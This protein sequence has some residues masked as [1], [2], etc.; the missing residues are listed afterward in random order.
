MLRRTL[1]ALLVCLSFSIRAAAQTLTLTFLNVGQADATLVLTPEGRTILVDAGGPPGVMAYLDELEIDTL[2]LVIASHNHSD[3]IGGM[4]EVLETVP[5]RFYLDNGVPHTTATYRRALTALEQ[6]GA[7]YL[8][9]TAR[10]I[11]VGSVQVRILPLPPG[12]EG[13]ND[14]SVGV[15]LEFGEFRALLTGDSEIAELAY[16]L[17]NAAV[18]EMHVLKVAH[19]GSRNGTTRAW[20]EHTR[21]EVAVISVG[22][23]NSYGHP[24]PQVVA[25]WHDVGADVLRTDL[26]GTIEINAARDG[27]FEIATDE[28][29]AEAEAAADTAPALSCC[30]IC[31]T[32]KACGNSCISR[33]LT[34]HRPPGCACNAKP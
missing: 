32:G 11:T 23:G 26:H 15:V 19:H 3:H 6:S 18:P 25:Q 2:D 27:S 21:P 4:A 34:C 28:P 5:V 1:F 14:N 20:A 29:V 31:T 22:A 17:A 13:Q 24:S 16:W 7:Q 10:T 8:R 33:R 12:A 30:R 9:A